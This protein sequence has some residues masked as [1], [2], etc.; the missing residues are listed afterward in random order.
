MEGSSPTPSTTLAVP[1]ATTSAGVHRSTPSPSQ[2]SSCVDGVGHVEQTKYPGKV[3]QGTIAIRIYFPP[4]YESSAERYP[5]LY[6]LHGY[7]FNESHWDEL[8]V[9][10]VVEVGIQ[11]GRWQPFIMVMPFLPQSLNVESDGGPGSYEE[12]ML[13]GL[14]P[15]IDENLRTIA[16]ADHRAIAGISRGAIWAMEISFRNPDQI[17][18]VAA[19][20]PALPMNRARPEYDPFIILQSTNRLPSKIFISVGDEEGGFRKKTE[21]LVSLMKEL[22]V[23]HRFLLASGGHEASTWMAVMEDLIIFVS[24]AW[25]QFPDP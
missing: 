2:T 1:A 8:G 6:L 19:L 7:P 4:C 11:I 9:D 5:V 23:P 10:E 18:I 20:S 17:A 15:F 12:E 21:E 25:N 3:S 13:E 14:V 22:G 24:D 16:D